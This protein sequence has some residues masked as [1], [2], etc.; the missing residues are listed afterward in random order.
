M[1]AYHLAIE[2]KMQGLK[3]KGVLVENYREIL[4]KKIIE[5]KDK[6]AYDRPEERLINSGIINVSEALDICIAAFP[7]LLWSEPDS[8]LNR[9]N[10][11]QQWQIYFLSRWV[12]QNNLV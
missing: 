9:T 11:I 6:L 8:I 3:G 7:D 10:P 5:R 1:Y 2:V 4:P 12:S